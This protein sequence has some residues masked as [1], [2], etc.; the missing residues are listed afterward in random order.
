MVAGAWVGGLRAEELVV[1]TVG[2]DDLVVVLFVVDGECLVE[3]EEVGVGTTSG[4]ALGLRDE[5]E[6][7]SIGE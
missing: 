5:D 2:G 3:D 1:A 4:A 6:A 7:G